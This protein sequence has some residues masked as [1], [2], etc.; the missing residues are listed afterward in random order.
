VKTASKD[1]PTKKHR[2]RAFPRWTASHVSS[3]R[4]S[5]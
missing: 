5:F 1:V 2:F 3:I 4:P